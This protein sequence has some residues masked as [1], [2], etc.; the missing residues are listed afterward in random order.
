MRRR[1]EQRDESATPTDME[2][3]LDN[4]YGSITPNAPVKPP[5]RNVFSDGSTRVDFVLVWEEPINLQK[6]ESTVVNPAHRKKREA[7]LNKLRLSRL[8]LEQ[9]DVLQTKTKVTFVLLSAPWSVLCFYA[10][11][12]SLR[13]PLQVVNSPIINWS[14][15]FLSRLSLH[16]PFSQDVPNPPPQCFTCQFR[17]NKLQR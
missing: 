8:L 12:I 11:E 4:S 7:F 13:V 14:E 5:D 9:K 3:E 10:E 15:H 16:N 6:E 2:T 17:T 1:E